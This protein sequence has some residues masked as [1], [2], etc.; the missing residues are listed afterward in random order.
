VISSF[1]GF[2]LANKETIID[3]LK[4]GLTTTLVFLSL[5]LL[6]PH[7][8]AESKSPEIIAE[9]WAMTPKSGKSGDFQV[10]L[11]DHSKHRAELKDPRK[12]DLYSQIL[13]NNMDTV[14]ARSFG[15]TWADMDAYA[16]WSQDKN[17]GQHFNDMVMPNVSNLGHYLSVIDV[18]NSHWG[19]EV[20]FRYVGVS[21]Y[22]VK[23]GHQGAMEKDIKLFSDVAKENNWD[24]NWSWA[25][26][27]GS[28]GNM[29]LAI[30]YKNWAAM[31]PPEQEFNEMMAKHL[32]S[33]KKAKKVFERWQSH[34][35]SVEYNVYVLRTDLMP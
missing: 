5:S 25:Q 28:E 26:G 23:Q 4:Y 34:F 3:K 30:P 31:A 9:S 20:T 22:H 32:K 16:S 24:Y 2:I 27:V 13:G 19:P 11:K 17:P 29:S 12:W 1:E 6:I 10:A 14:I 18:V 21:S 35:E 7:A 8:M 15:F 33:E